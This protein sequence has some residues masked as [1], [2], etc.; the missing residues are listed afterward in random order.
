MIK[1]IVGPQ[2][3]FTGN[4]DCTVSCIWQKKEKDNTFTYPKENAYN[5]IGCQV[6]SKIHEVLFSTLNWREH[7]NEAYGTWSDR[8]LRAVRIIKDN[9]PELGKISDVNEFASYAIDNIIPHFY[10]LIPNSP[11]A[12]TTYKTRLNAIENYLTMMLNNVADFQRNSSISQ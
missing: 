5:A 4:I 9:L 12:A 8:Q 2:D 7:A 11:Q 1:V 6:R 10:C 3:I